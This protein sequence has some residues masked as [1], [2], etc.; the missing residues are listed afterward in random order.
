MIAL[1]F[2]E[3][4]IRRTIVPFQGCGFDS[5]EPQLSNLNRHSAMDE[6]TLVKESVSCPAAASGPAPAH[7][8]L[9][10]QPQPC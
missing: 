5:N 10:E 9:I 8:G 7:E 2:S 3:S 1:G 4:R 6:K